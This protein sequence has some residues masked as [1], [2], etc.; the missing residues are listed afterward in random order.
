MQGQEPNSPLSN[1]V[2]IEGDPVVVDTQTVDF[3]VRHTT[4][5]KKIIHPFYPSAMIAMIMN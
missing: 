4:D 1:P 3:P 5:S 2:G